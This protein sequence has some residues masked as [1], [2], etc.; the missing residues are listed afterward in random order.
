MCQFDNIN[1]NN[2]EQLKSFRQFTDELSYEL[3]NNDNEIK[4]GKDTVEVDQ[5]EE[6]VSK[7]IYIVY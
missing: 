4:K 2:K 7:L 3:I 5:N 1:Q 6:P